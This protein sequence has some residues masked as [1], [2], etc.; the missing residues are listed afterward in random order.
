LNAR[1]QAGLT[2]KVI[3]GLTIDSK[4][5][6]EMINSDTKNIYDGSTYTVRATVN[7]AST[8]DKAT[9]IVTPNL[10]LG[11]FLDQNRNYT[12]AYNWRNQLNYNKLIAKRHQITVIAGAEV[13]S[14]VNQYFSNPR[15]YGYDNEKLTVGTFPNGIGGSGI[16]ALKNW[17]GAAQTFAYTNSYTYSTDRYFSMYG[18]ASY[19]LDSKYTL[20]G[21]ART[22]ASN[23]ITDDPKYRFAPFWSVGASWAISKEKFM[24]GIGWLDRL[25]VRATYGFNGNVDK[26]T[27][28]L[29]LINVTGTQNIY[30]QD[31]T[32]TIGS[33]GNPALRWEKTGTTNLGSDFDFLG[34]KISGK[35]DLYNKKGRDLIVGMSIP[36][37]NGTAT[38]KLNMA[39]MTNK[40]IELELGT[41]LNL[42]GKDIVWTG[43]FNFSYNKNTIDKLYKATY[44]AYDL[45]NGGTTAYVQGFDANTLWSLKYT[46]VVNKGTDAVPNWQPTVQGKGTDLYDFTAWTPG[47][48][49]DYMLDMGSKV[50]PFAM[51]LN[52]TFSVYDFDFSFIVTGKF[53]HVFNGY[54]FNYPSMIGG[55]AL[56]NSLYSEILNS[57]P[58]DRVPIPFGKSEPRYYFWDRFYPNLDYRVQNAG[59]IRMQEINITYNL[60][61]SILNKIGINSAKL[62]A[63]GNNLFII[64]NNKYNEDPEYPLGTIRPQASFTFG[65]N[66]GL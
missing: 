60:P 50:A 29:P 21:S 24:Q 26:S 31:Y 6:Y 52:S 65:L 3:E 9:G 38:Q 7:Y 18:N 32:A 53:G 37:V 64:A 41:F 2:F 63:Q 16:Y 34:G 55:S 43:S 13:S 57:D 36:A 56:P 27:S 28:F 22:D 1:T 20:S 61:R 25:V 62:F 35:L 66:L 5:Q 15:T 30:I 17:S 51:G 48:G 42:K 49:R 33:Y 39:E 12:T 54:N 45:F 47:D 40:G 4:I 44:P 46:G 23:L 8:W 14:M 10:P 59:H 58:M 19:T 11:G